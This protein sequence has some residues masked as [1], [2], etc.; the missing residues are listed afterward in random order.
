MEYLGKIWLKSSE[1]GTTVWKHQ[2]L[3]LQELEGDLLVYLVGSF[4]WN[5]CK[6]INILV[7]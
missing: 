4:L 6:G 3:L 2:E 7:M 5:S 1:P